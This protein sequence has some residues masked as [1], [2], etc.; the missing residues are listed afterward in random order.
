VLTRNAPDPEP[1][2]SG[3]EVNGKTHGKLTRAN[4]HLSA[5]LRTDPEPKQRRQCRAPKPP[6]TFLL[7]AASVLLL[8]LA[9]AQGYVSWKA[10]FTFIDAAKRE[11]LPSTLEALGLDTGAII[12]ALLGLAHARMGRSAKIERTLNLACAFG[13]MTMNLLGADLASPRSVAVYVL[14]ALLYAACSD[15]LIATAGH[16]AGQQETSLW[17]WV[18]VGLLYGLR[19]CLAFPS[20]AKGLRLRLLQLTPL[21]SGPEVAQISVNNVHADTPPELEAPAR[22]GTKKAALLALYATH[23]DHGIRAKVTAVAKELGPQAGLH[24]S[25]ARTTLYAYLAGGKS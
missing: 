25:S 12:F 20:T 8:L 22:P 21:P 23:P 4:G 24:P 17:R 13:S 11:R 14:P 2:I 18:G 7:V 5:W 1:C 3:P 16:L 19:A 6:G 10:Q 9:A 15:R